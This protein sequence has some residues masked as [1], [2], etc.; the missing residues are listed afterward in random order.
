MPLELNTLLTVAVLIGGLG[1]GAAARR[2]RR[3]DGFRTL[4]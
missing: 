1:A 4:P 3:R 2:T